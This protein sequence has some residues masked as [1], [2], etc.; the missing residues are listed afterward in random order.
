[1][2]SKRSYGSS[3]V[4][5]GI[6]IV[7]TPKMAKSTAFR[8]RI[9]LIATETRYPGSFFTKR[10]SRLGRGGVIGCS[11]SEVVGDMPLKT[12]DPLA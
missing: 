8:R 6:K 11:G 1:M 5:D 10:K 9:M 3:S 2:I 4:P 12:V 7:I